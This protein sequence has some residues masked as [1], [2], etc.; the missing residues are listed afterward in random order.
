MKMFS[1]TTV[2][3]VSD[4]TY[5]L[6]DKDMEM[7]S[8]LIIGK[9][10]CILVDTRQNISLAKESQSAVKS[11]TNK[12]I[13]YLINTHYHGDH[14]FG[15]QMFIEAQDIIG[16]KN[17][18]TTLLE[19]GEQHKDLFR[20]FFGV[21]GMDEVVITPPTLTFE[22]EL[23]LQ[24]D[25]ETINIFHTNNAHTDTDCYIY[26]PE[27]KLLIT[28]DLFNNQII[29]FTGDP[30]SSLSGWI[31]AIQEMAEL[32]IKTVIPGHG[33][34]GKKEDLIVYRQYFEKLQTVAKQEF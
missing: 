31:K 1:S 27:Q 13:K 32:D 11:I 16:H 6:I 26:I 15:N 2:Q 19:T 33:P 28:G 12:P 3:K 34:F 4:N 20:D 24:F 21:S 8:T 22:K 9:K 5:V 29:G 23:S 17:A 10:D 14:T 18:R 30:Q 25:N 7:N